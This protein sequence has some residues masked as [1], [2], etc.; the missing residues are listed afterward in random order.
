MTELTDITGPATPA[1]PVAFPQDRNCPYHPPTGYAPLR[2]AR[3]LARVSLY[4]GREVWMV[5]GHAL[6]RSL[7]ADPR[8]S[9]DRRRGE[10]PSISPASRASATGGWRCSART[11]PSTSGSGG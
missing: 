5:T 4:D 2:E 9:S 3:P 11:T 7:L 8:L 6:A 10:F 1:D